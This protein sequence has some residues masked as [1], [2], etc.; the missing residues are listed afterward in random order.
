VL[1]VRLDP[2]LKPRTL[3]IARPPVD[4]AFFFVG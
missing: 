1:F 4:R 2:R 3:G